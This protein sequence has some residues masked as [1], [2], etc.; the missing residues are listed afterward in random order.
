MLN[1]KKNGA[2]RVQVRTVVTKRALTCAPVFAHDLEWLA[3]HCVTFVSLSG[4]H[5]SIRMCY[6]LAA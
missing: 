2:H 3:R 1:P 5:E 4:R 6:H